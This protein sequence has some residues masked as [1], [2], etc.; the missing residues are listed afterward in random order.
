MIL[1]GRVRIRL[2]ARSAGRVDRRLAEHAARAE[3]IGPTDDIHVGAGFK[4]LLERFGRAAVER[5]G[6]L[7]K[8]LEQIAEVEEPDQGHD[9][10]PDRGAGDHEVDDAEAHRVD[11]V[12]LLAELIVGKELHL[13]PIGEAVGRQA[14]DEIVVVDPAVG[15]LRVV[16]QRGRKA[17]R[18]RSSAGG[19]HH[20]R[21]ERH[22]D[23][24]GPAIHALALHGETSHPRPDSVILSTRHINPVT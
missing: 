3:I 16:R 23:E 13:D 19:A 8:A 11:D 18:H 5:L 7:G 12:D 20:R 6:L 1:L 4:R 15:E 2:P 17:Q 21:R 24:Q 10:G 22:A 9:I 14:L